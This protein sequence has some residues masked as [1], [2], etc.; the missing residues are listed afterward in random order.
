ME[1]LIIWLRSIIANLYLLCEKEKLLSLYLF[2]IR[3]WATLKRGKNAV[4][5]KTW[6]FPWKYNKFNIWCSKW[7]ENWI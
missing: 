3:K 1:K 6:L 4:Y 7:S 5:S 2:S